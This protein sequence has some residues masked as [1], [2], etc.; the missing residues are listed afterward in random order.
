MLM[1]MNPMN[2]QKINTCQARVKWLAIFLL[3]ATARIALAQGV[4]Q[5]SLQE[6]TKIEKADGPLYESNNP[7]YIL[8]RSDDKDKCRSFSATNDAQIRILD[9]GAVGNVILKH[10]ELEIQA[11]GSVIGYVEA[12][13][14]MTYRFLGQEL[15][16]NPAGQQGHITVAAGGMLGTAL[17]GADSSLT[18][19][20]VGGTTAK[21]GW[22][23]T[24]GTTRIENA[25][26]NPNYAY[27]QGDGL[28]GALLDVT[29][30]TTII[31]NSVI[32]GAAK[33]DSKYGVQMYPGFGTSGTGAPVLAP[34]VYIKNVSI[35]GAGGG[36]LVNQAMKLSDK[37]LPA[38]LRIENSEVEST[39]NAALQLTATGKPNDIPA[40]NVSVNAS[41]FS[42]PVALGIFGM[43][44]SI[45]LT[46]GGGSTLM[47]EGAG[48]GSAVLIKG[49]ALV[50][51]AQSTQISGATH[52]IELVPIPPGSL[53][54]PPGARVLVT[55]GTS[56]VG[57]DGAA[58]YING[59]TDA[60]VLVSAG[61]TLT[62]ANGNIVQFDAGDATV[63]ADGVALTG[64]VL[65]RQGKLTLDQRSAST[66]QGNLSVQDGA[67]TTALI[68]QASVM[69]GDVAVGGAGSDL[70]LA[71]ADGATLSGDVSASQ[72][73]NLNALLSGN[74]TRM[75]GGIRV[76]GGAKGS[77][78]LEQGATL[79]NLRG[80]AVAADDGATLDLSINGG[81]RVEASDGVLVLAG[82]A[83]R[84]TVDV[85][86]SAAPLRGDMKLSDWNAGK[87]DIRLANPGTLEQPSVLGNIS[88]SSISL[89]NGA[90]WQFGADANQRVGWLR[91]NNGVV[92]F[93]SG[94]FKILSVGTLKQENG[95][96]SRINLRT[97]FTA[98]LSSTTGSDQVKVEQEIAGRHNL[99]IANV[100]PEGEGVVEPR[101]R[102]Q[103]SVAP[104]AG[105][106]QLSPEAYPEKRLAIGNYRYDLVREGDNWL[107]TRSGESNPSAPVDPADLSSFAQI[108]LAITSAAP[109]IWQGELG[110]L[111][112][113][114]GDL[115]ENRAGS[116]VWGRS[117]GNA[118][119]LQ[120]TEIPGYELKQYGVTFGADKYFAADTSGTYVGGFGAYSNS[121]LKVNG[122]SSGRVNSYSIGAYATWL[123]EQGWYLDGVLKANYLANDLKAGGGDSAPT[124]GNY[125]TPGIGLS[126]EFGKRIPLPRGG[127]MEPYVRTAAFTARR[128]SV[129]LDNGFDISAGS[130]RSVIGELGMLAGQRYELSSQR[131]LQPYLR[132]AVVHEFVSNNTTRMNGR[133]FGNSISGTQGLLGLGV[134]LQ[135]GERL[136]LH[137]DVDY[138]AGKPID[139][140]LMATVGLRYAW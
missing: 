96:A 67:A 23:T 74:T 139:Q 69:K 46:V 64:N 93:G 45:D 80:T 129:E 89:T 34:D 32:D 27:D 136:Q 113:R 65:A 124:R 111:R 53:A 126:L 119:R 125:R 36:V 26:I 81:A 12:G 48:A 63:V 31:T 2:F 116:G 98:G 37:P 91:M 78:V 18:V 5:P 70:T 47:S 122:G 76:T 100:S 59:A 108:G 95:G 71:V 62:G 133:T 110:L 92:D 120:D 99:A 3:A 109:L 134:A 13:E 1:E 66:L 114:Q 105:G 20:R 24:S 117:Y 68:R 38:T 90:L 44:R 19:G 104:G 6:P 87:L 72:Q 97:D 130:D 25:E 57:R 54:A 61:S 58:I 8:Q 127:F 60:Q 121:E 40:V 84:V 94:A 50:T 77:V 83:S 10:G 49:S 30:G 35:R 85:A 55:G 102:V 132:A 39:R 21:L 42:G 9:G 101:T 79:S 41:K 107:L 51:L 4:C 22:V 131:T 115:R 15:T 43:N 73:A 118:S 11:G 103:I 56:V 88:A 7:D 17:I 138:A 137:A 86:D 128:A 135:S 106:F 112:K 33:S 16:L 14:K 82:R 140:S 52:G 75:Q 28:N 29:G 123:H